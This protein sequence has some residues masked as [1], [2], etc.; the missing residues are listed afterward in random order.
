MVGEQRGDALLGRL[1]REDRRHR[2]RGEARTCVVWFRYHVP[3]ARPGGP[4]S[5]SA[6]RRWRRS[7]DD[8]RGG[9]LVEDDEHDRARPRPARRPPRSPRRHQVARRRQREER[10]EGHDGQAGEQLA[11]HPEALGPHGEH[12]ARQR[13]HRGQR[14]SATGRA[15]PERSC[16]AASPTSSPIDAPWT[17]TR[18]RGANQA[19]TRPSRQSTSGGTEDD[20]KREHHE[21]GA[22]GVAED[23][24]LGALPEGVEH[25]LGDGEAGGTDERRQAAELL[26]PLDVDVLAPPC[27]CTRRRVTP[28]QPTPITRRRPELRTRPAGAATSSPFGRA[29]GGRMPTTH[30]STR[31]RRVADQRHRAPPGGGRSRGR[32]ARRALPRVPRAVVLVAPP[33]PRARRRRL[34]R[35]R[36]RPARLRRVRPARRRSRTTTSTTSPATCSACSTTS[37]P[38]R[39]CS[40]ATTGA[41]WSSARW[42]CC[43]PIG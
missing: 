8:R 42:R 15:A 43:T 25:R 13:R 11:P 41:R 28:G 39:R 37:A 24:G 20:A 36:P 31:E 30:P 7:V 9:Q 40:S 35:A 34:P 2:V 26:P 5:G 23:E 29:R 10:D 4:G 14:R 3:A 27:R 6:P 19:T 12:P 22:G 38:S 18:H 21:V 1:A 32:P 17:N 33:D 16:T